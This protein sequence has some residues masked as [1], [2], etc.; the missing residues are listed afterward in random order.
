MLSEERRPERPPKGG[1]GLSWWVSMKELY[2]LIP[3]CRAPPPITP[4]SYSFEYVC[5]SFSRTLRPTLPQGFQTGN[6]QHVSFF[7]EYK[8]QIQHSH[9]ASSIK[10]KPHCLMSCS[11]PALW[12]R[13]TQISSCQSRS[14][15][16]YPQFSLGALQPPP[17]NGADAGWGHCTAPWVI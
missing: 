11:S 13:Q 4:G 17:L 16:R 15:L 2:L 3:T 1:M 10:Y 9:I 12:K 5:H 8:N 6:Y 7:A 14:R